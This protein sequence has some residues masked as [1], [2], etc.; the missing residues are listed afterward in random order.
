MSLAEELV[1]LR[2]HEA[3]HRELDSN[4]TVGVHGD[5]AERR[6]AVRDAKYVLGRYGA[7]GG[8]AWDHAEPIRFACDEESLKVRFESR[9]QDQDQDQQ[10]GGADSG[11]TGACDGAGAAVGAGGVVVGRGAALGGAAC[12][13]V[14]EAGFGGAPSGV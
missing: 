7:E 6:R 2:L 13:V 5:L 14:R 8:L 11:H 9:E 12:G 10:A 3:T 4:L 1:L